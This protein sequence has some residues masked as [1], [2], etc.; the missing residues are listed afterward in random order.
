MSLES[1]EMRC[2]KCGQES[3][4]EI[5]CDRP[6]QVTVTNASSGVDIE[7]NAEGHIE[8]MDSDSARCPECDWDGFV[9]DLTVCYTNYHRED[10]DE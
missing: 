4:F 9:E 3:M 7:V 5:N 2:P 10:D 8:W 1:L 6:T